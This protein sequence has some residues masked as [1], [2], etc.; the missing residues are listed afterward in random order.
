MGPEESSQEPIVFRPIPPDV[1][2]DTYLQTLDSVRKGNETISPE[3]IKDKTQLLDALNANAKDLSVVIRGGGNITKNEA[4][5]GGT[6]LEMYQAEVQSDKVPGK[7]GFNENGRPR[8]GFEIVLPDGSGKPNWLENNTFTLTE[9]D[10][11]GN[12]VRGIDLK[13]DLSP[14]DT[15]LFAKR[16]QTAVS[17]VTENAA[18]PSPIE[19][20]A[21]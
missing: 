21:A 2:A 11:E 4:N 1:K 16:Y 17:K 6:K 12:F 10:D 3:A 20:P 8:G 18:N 19:T 13:K 14:E 15:Q 7:A 5:L 9:L